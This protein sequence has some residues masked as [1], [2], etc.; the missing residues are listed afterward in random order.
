MVVW[1]T[2]S[3]NLLFEKRANRNEREQ[4]K[5]DI[6]PDPGAIAIDPMDTSHPMKSQKNRVKSTWLKEQ[7][8]QK[9][10]K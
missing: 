4:R 2:G 9:Q 6:A 10:T 5:S 3:W 7:T 1:K 8:C